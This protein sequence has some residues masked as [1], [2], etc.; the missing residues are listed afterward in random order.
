MFASTASLLSV[1]ASVLGYWIQHKSD[2]HDTVAVQYHLALER[3]RV[4]SPVAA[5]SMEGATNSG[6]TSLT[7]SGGQ[8]S[9]KMFEREKQLILQNRGWRL[10]LSQ[11]LTQLWHS[12]V[13]VFVIL[14]T[15]CSLT[16]LKSCARCG[17]HAVPEKSIE[18]GSTLLTK[19]GAVTHIVHLM[20][21]DDI[22]I[23]ASEILGN[24]ED[25]TMD[26]L[27]IIG[28]FYAIRKEEVGAIFRDHFGL[29]DGFDVAFY[30]RKGKKKR[31][32]S[33][34]I[35]SKT[36]SPVFPPIVTAALKDF[37]HGKGGKTFRAMTVEEKMAKMM[38]AAERKKTLRRVSSISVPTVSHNLD[39]SV[40]APSVGDVKNYA[41]E[42]KEDSIIQ[43]TESVMADDAK[44]SDV[45]MNGK[46]V[47]ENAMDI[48][49]LETEQMDEIIDDIIVMMGTADK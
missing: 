9:A 47:V 18:I 11:S 4:L 12:L 1:I 46:D 5:L 10:K 35:D 24:R 48:D 6:S 49:G 2:D 27:F 7:P 8:S 14:W 13:N 42:A 3:H 43:W 17:H 19:T 23:Y 28:Q 44:K 37:F 41:D 22:E 38:K 45:N 34:S 15:C 39:I 40:P 21:K 31:A 33:V 20:K 32:L 29:G 30:C 16:N 26:E 36:A 25:T